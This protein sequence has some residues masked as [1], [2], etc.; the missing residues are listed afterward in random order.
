MQKRK[1]MKLQSILFITCISFSTLSLPN[2]TYDSEMR[3]YHVK[4][5][6]LIGS[7]QRIGTINGYESGIVKMQNK[8]SINVIEKPELTST[9]LIG[10]IKY[11]NTI[12][13]SGNS[14]K[15]SYLY[16]AEQS[17]NRA[18]IEN[19]KKKHNHLMA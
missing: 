2:N 6:M 1:L 7:Y 11:K 12:R 10:Y 14:T 15:R 19:I 5:H 9:G 13:D 17:E 3:V 16:Q 18:D 8:T 4:N